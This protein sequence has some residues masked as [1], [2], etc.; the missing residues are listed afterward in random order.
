M[1]L[2][3]LLGGFKRWTVVSCFSDHG[4]TLR[5]DSAEVFADS[6]TSSVWSPSRPAARRLP[7]RPQHFRSGMPCGCRG[8]PSG[9]RPRRLAGGETNSRHIGKRTACGG[10][11]GSLVVSQFGT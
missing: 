7:E 9:R 8:L 10:R 11:A 6:Q 2:M 1:G 4:I 5:T 3:C